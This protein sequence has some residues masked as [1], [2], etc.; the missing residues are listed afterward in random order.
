MDI[1][2]NPELDMHNQNYPLNRHQKLLEQLVFYNFLLKNGHEMKVISDRSMLDKRI[3]RL[4]Y[5]DFKI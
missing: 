4:N 5:N 2:I 1:L 3:P